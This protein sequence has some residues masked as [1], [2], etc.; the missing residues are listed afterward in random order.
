ML[1]VCV[2]PT[3]ASGSEVV[4]TVQLGDSDCANVPVHAPIALPK[5][6][7]DLSPEA[8]AVEVRQEGDKVVLPGQIVVGEEKQPQVWWVLPSGKAGAVTRWTA[9]LTRAT[10]ARKDVFAWRDEAGKHLDL[11]FDGRPVTRYM[12][13]YEP[14]DKNQRFKTAKPFHHVFDPTGQK[15][16]TSHGGQPYPHHRGIFIGWN[17]FTFEGKRYDLWHV[18]KAAQVHQNSL[19]QIAGPVLARSTALVH[20]NDT[21]G[22]ALVAEERET[23]VFRQTAPVM[24]LMRFRSRLTPIRGDVLLDGDPEHGGCQYRPHPQVAATNKQIAKEAKEAKKKGEKVAPHPDRTTYL[25]HKEG[26]NPRKDLDLPWVGMS[27]VLDGQRYSVQHLNHPGNPKKTRYSA[28]RDY[29]RFG[30]FFKKEIKAGE[31][32]ELRYG[33][34]VVAGGMP[35]RD[36]SAQRYAA[37]AA[38]PKVSVGK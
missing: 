25:F 18:R 29:G 27:Y 33:F 14:S 4:L 6:M 26:I 32:L 30:A 34:C 23:T 16:I 17:K 2:L 3:I 38:P 24:M 36:G 19:C 9:K 12:Y 22:E 5:D 35:G 10:E 31:T 37:F 15:L 8:I 13:A 21:K 7:A 28:Y 20:W 11:M 1:S